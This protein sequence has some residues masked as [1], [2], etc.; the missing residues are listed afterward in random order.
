M[1]LSWDAGPLSGPLEFTF[2]SLLNVMLSWKSCWK[3]RIMKRLVVLRE[4]NQQREMWPSCEPQRGEQLQSVSSEQAGGWRRGLLLWRTRM[5]ER[6]PIDVLTC[7][8][9]LLPSGETRTFL[10]HVSKGRKCSNKSSG[11]NLRK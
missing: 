4:W 1:S 5:S 2:F 10:I 11:F 3:W 7:I 8:L 9:C 6:E